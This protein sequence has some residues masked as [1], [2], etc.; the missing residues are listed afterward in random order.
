MMMAT[1][2]FAVDPLLV[3]DL[4]GATLAYIKSIFVGFKLLVHEQDMSK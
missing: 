2:L 1:T 4:N 3:T